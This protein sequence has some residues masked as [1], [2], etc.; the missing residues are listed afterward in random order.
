MMTAKS[1]ACANSCVGIGERRRR[2]RLVV[3]DARECAPTRRGS[4][5]GDDPNQRNDHLLPTRSRQDPIWPLTCGYG[6]RGGI[7]TST[8]RLR[9]EEPSSSRYQPDPFWLLT[10]AGS[11][12]ECVPDLSCYGWG[13]DQ[14]NDQADPGETQQSRTAFRSGSEG[15]SPLDAP[16]PRP[17][18]DHR[19]GTFRQKIECQGEQ[20]LWWAADPGSGSGRLGL[21]LRVAGVALGLLGLGRRRSGSPRGRG[22]TSGDLASHLAQLAA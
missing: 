6:A 13:N 15:A 11:S 12:V 14:G 19:S 9:V 10:S 1:E 18:S 3:C 21:L 17:S 7:R 20:L 22:L 8:F 5:G 2:S 4:P 16:S